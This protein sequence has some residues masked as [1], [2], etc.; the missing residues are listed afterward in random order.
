MPLAL[1]AHSLTLSSVG[2]GV[3]FYLPL[4]SWRSQLP[5]DDCKLQ[6]KGFP[7]QGDLRA[8]K[9]FFFTKFRFYLKTL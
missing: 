3:P 1:I 2:V 9:S 8:L 7:I 6:R 4:A 5:Q